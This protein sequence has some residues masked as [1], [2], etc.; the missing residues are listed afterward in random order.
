[1]MAAYGD[2]LRQRAHRASII[3]ILLEW[4]MACAL[5]QENALDALGHELA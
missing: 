4:P 1:M 2:V 5:A 3:S